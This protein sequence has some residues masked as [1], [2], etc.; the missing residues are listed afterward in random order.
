MIGYNTAKLIAGRLQ[1]AMGEKNAQESIDMHRAYPF[2]GV[3]VE[4]LWQ[5]GCPACHGSTRGR[6]AC[7]RSSA[8]PLPRKD[9]EPLTT[10]TRGSA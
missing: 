6:P 2:S 4:R 8:D 5:P 10:R 1:P 7:H 9:L 3:A